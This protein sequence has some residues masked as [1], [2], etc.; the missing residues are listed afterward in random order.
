MPLRELA[1]LAGTAATCVALGIPMAKWR[2]E[3]RKQRASEIVNN[4]S[5]RWRLRWALPDDAP[6][7]MRMVG[8]LA[9][10]EKLLHEVVLS[11]EQ[12]RTDFN[13]GRF[14]CLLCEPTN[15]GACAGFA[16]VFHTYSTFEGKCLYLEDLYVSPQARGSGAGIALLRCVAG[17][18]RDRNCAR[19]QWQA[20]DWNEKAVAFY[21]SS[22]VGARQ[23]ISDDGTTWL[24]FIMNRD[25]ISRLAGC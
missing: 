23:R 14:E 7:I 6:L 11:V 25:E 4:S 15:G 16:L 3:A 19:L 18:A 13:E 20:L 22:K 12:C 9:E 8:E 17:V 24:N 21:Q 10:F 1:V 5:S 2:A